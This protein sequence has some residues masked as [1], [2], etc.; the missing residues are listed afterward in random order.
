MNAEVT[1]CK[2]TSVMVSR[3]AKSE[4]EYKAILPEEY[5]DIIC[6]DIN[7]R[8]KGQ[9]LWHNMDIPLADVPY[10]VDL[11]KEYC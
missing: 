6:I 4:I 8:I 1:K 10:L 2:T 11:L 3:E 5:P 9:D 7:G